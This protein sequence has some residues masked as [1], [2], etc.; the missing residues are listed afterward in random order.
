[1]EWQQ[2][3]SPAHK[4]RTNK[5]ESWIPRTCL[6]GVCGKTDFITYFIYMGKFRNSD[7][8]WYTFRVRERCTYERTED[9]RISNAKS[10]RKRI[11]REIF[12]GSALFG[13]MNARVLLLNIRNFEHRASGEYVRIGLTLSETSHLVNIAK[14]RIA[15]FGCHS[16]PMLRNLEYWVTCCAV[17]LRYLRSAAHSSRWQCVCVWYYSICRNERHSALALSHLP[18]WDGVTDKHTFYSVFLHSILLCV[19]LFLV[20]GRC[21]PAMAFHS[22]H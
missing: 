2:Q 5:C 12:V 3:H 4:P 13:A 7:I 20:A 6:F 1:M 21:Y 10:N 8:N 19:S 15:I 16:K 14:Q 18:Q 17:R 11:E 22:L 9:E